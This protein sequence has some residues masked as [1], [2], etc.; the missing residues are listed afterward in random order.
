MKL[1]GALNNIRLRNKMLIIYFI[2]VLIPVILTNVIFYNITTNNVKK[3]KMKDLSLAIEQMRNELLYQIDTVVGITAV[4]YNDSLLNEYLEQQYEYTSDYV[5]NYHSYITDMLEKYTPVYGAIQKINIFTD[6]DT[7]I[8]G[9]SVL[10]ISDIEK[11]DWYKTLQNSNTFIP[12]LVSE[13]VSTSQPAISIVRKMSNTVGQDEYEKVIKIDLHPELI[14]Q[15]FSNVMFEGNVI[16][17]ANDVVQYESNPP[18]RGQVNY[19]DARQET[20]DNA[21]V[22]EESYPAVKYLK[23]WRIIGKFQ[24]K[25]VLEDV[26]KSKEFVL[27]MA[28]PNILVPTLIIIWFTRSLNE[29][30]IRILKHMKRVKNQSFETI[31]NEETKD[32]IG[33]LM[34]EF[35][36][37]TLQIKSLIRDVYM[38]DIQKKELE[39]KRNQS[40]L[41]ALQSQI[42][43]H[44]L[45]NALETIRMRSLIKEETETA[46]IIANMAKIFRA[47]LT[48][49]KDRVTVDGEME[50]ILCFLQIQKY[51]FEDRLDYRI[52]IDPSAKNCIVPKMMFL[53]FVENACLHG[54][55]RLKRG[56]R[57]DIRIE[58][59]EDTLLFAILDNGIGMDEEMVKRFY[60]YLESEEGI[61]ERIGVQNVMYRLKLIYKDRCRLLIDSAPGKGTYIRLQIPVE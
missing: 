10:S 7:I 52:H 46:K 44:F 8:Y 20:E 37:M 12:I 61:G 27:Y 42:N 5:N 56:G 18:Q 19:G 23:D 58:R 29:R 57:I 22:L 14:K 34:M 24:E 3:Q 35:N 53:P 49:G 16:L 21:I 54:I 55:E 28:L 38:A 30:L 50:F 31:D 6:N 40:Q 60:S 59:D 36:R 11:E 1:S 33:Q 48:W 32:E 4:L 43:P 41:H 47:S 2:S 9:G 26:R 15:L 25:K 39:L 13:T 45:F 51:R 17:L